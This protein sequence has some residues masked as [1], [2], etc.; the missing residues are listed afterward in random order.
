[1]SE[2]YLMLLS[3]VL[4]VPM[5]KNRNLGVFFSP[6]FFL[7]GTFLLDKSM[8]HSGWY[9][10]IYVMAG[11]AISAIG[12]MIARPDNAAAFL[13]RKTGATCQTIQVN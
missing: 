7:A 12:L 5:R 6:I 4:Q 8:A 3:G 10:D 9:M 13:N 2:F 11:T 1:M